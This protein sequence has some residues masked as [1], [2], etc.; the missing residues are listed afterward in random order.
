VDEEVS[1]VFNSF[2]AKGTPSRSF[3]ASFSH[4][5]PSGGFIIEYTPHEI[6]FLFGDTLFSRVLSTT[7]LFLLVVGQNLK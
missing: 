6:F 5:V 4:V 7:R 1:V 3:N 2:F